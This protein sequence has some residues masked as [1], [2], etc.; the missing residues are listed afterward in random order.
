MPQ[1]H[2]VKSLF[3]KCIQSTKV[4]DDI[5]SK[6]SIEMLY[7]KCIEYQRRVK[8]GIIYDPEL[9]AANSLYSK[10]TRNKKVVDKFE[11]EMLENFVPFSELDVCD[12]CQHMQAIGYQHKNKFYQIKFAEKGSKTIALKRKFKNVNGFTGSC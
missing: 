5:L 1:Q 7:H 2:R 3:E 11:R 12:I 4:V 6:H 9:K 8:S 10:Y